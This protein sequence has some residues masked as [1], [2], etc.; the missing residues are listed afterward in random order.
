MTEK[1]IFELKQVVVAKAPAPPEQHSLPVE[2]LEKLSA[3]T[4]MATTPTQYEVSINAIKVLLN[5]LEGVLKGETTDVFLFSDLDE[6]YI[7]QYG[8]CGKNNAYRFLLCLEEEVSNFRDRILCGQEEH[9][10]DF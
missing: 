8:L 7:N 2:I 9:Y 1:K 6:F 5:N 4:E 3:I 10:E